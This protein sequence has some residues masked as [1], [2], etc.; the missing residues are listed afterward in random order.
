MQDLKAVA[1]PHH[2][3]P[4]LGVLAHALQDGGELG[5]GPAAQVI[6]V[7]EAP[8]K[9]DR[10][11]VLQIGVL[12]PEKDRLLSQDRLEHVVGIVIAV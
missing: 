8:W 3:F 12:V 11:H 4:F 7:S 1:N 5:D 6:S 10:V 9:D 2:Q